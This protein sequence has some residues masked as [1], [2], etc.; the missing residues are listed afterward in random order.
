MWKTKCHRY[1]SECECCTVAPETNIDSTSN[2]T[3]MVYTV[4]NIKGGCQ[5]NIFPF[6]WFNAALFMKPGDKQQLIAGSVLADD[7]CRVRDPVSAENSVR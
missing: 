1:I 4:L 2:P 6:V 5:L 7:T 3:D